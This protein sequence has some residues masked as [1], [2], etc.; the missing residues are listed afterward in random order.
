MQPAQLTTE[1]QFKLTTIKRDVDNL[2]LEQAKEYIIKLV[3]QGMLKDQL[4]REWMKK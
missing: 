4:I 1:Q 3:E 2:S